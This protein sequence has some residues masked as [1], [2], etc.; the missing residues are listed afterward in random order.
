MQ[1]MKV[2]TVQMEHTAGDKQA[3]FAKVESFI[4]DAEKQNVELIAFPECCLT[5]YWFLRNLTRPQLE[6]LAEPVPEGPS[7]ARLL[8]LAQTH[9]MTV[10]AGLVEQAS[11]GQL[12]NTYLV[13][14]PDGRFARH[15]KIHCFISP[16]LASGSEYTVF[17]LP[18]GTKTG[19]LICYDNNLSENCRVTALMGAEI[20]LAPHQTGGC[21]T[22][23]VHSLGPID[24]ALWHNRKQNPAPIE[25]EFQGPKGRQWL[26]RWLPARAFDNGMFLIFSNGVG[27]D[28][29]EI[30]TGNATIFDCF[31][32]ILAATDRPED[33]MLTADLDASLRANCDGCR[34]IRARRP[35]LYAPLTQTTGREQDIRAVRFHYL[36][37]D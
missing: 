28:D 32:R 33:V 11:D 9:Q 29:D 27:V 7:S 19:I 12:Y 5:G 16:H 18:N 30:R 34:R 22:G 25:A 6:D 15:R 4:A 26:M 10:A 23:C 8:Q 35:E 17:D 1:D 31:G 13:A 21:Q 3:N 37:P 36:D 14:M 24:P 20:L 2:A